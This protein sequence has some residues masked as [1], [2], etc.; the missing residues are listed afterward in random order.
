MSPATAEAFE[1][2]YIARDCEASQAWADGA[3]IRAH[4]IRRARLKANLI[5][6]AMLPLAVEAARSLV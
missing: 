3:R 2:E 6:A 1:L 5:L 4:R